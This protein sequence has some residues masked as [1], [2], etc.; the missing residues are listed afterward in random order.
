MFLKEF[1]G[2]NALKDYFRK[3]VSENRVPH[4]IL[5]VG[6]EGH[7]KLALSLGLAALLQCNNKEN[8]QACGTC[9]SCT[10]ASQLIHPDIHFSFPVIKKE[11][12]LKR[13]ETTSQHF[14]EQWRSFVAAHPYGNINDWMDHLGASDKS[15]NINVAECNQV[16]K[17]LG[18]KTYE[19]K[20]KI[21]IIWAAKYLGKEGNR[22][23]KLIEEPTPDTIII[24]I[25]DNRNALLNTIRSRCQIINVPPFDDVQIAELIEAESQLSA[26]DQQELTYLAAGNMRKVVQML[27][28]S[29]M[30][31]SEDILSWLRI[32][33]K[34]DPDEI[35]EFVDHLLSKGK[36]DLRNFMS[37]G[38][39]FL[40]EYHMGIMTGRLDKLR[41]TTV[42]KDVA[43]KMQKI[44]DGP[45]TEAL[46][47]LMSKGISLINRNVSL[48]ILIINLTLEIHDILRSTVDS[49][50]TR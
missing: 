31:Y 1:P 39:H 46:E 2:Q 5:M 17:N 20:Y 12:S 11:G 4:A 37:Y 13:A 23:L 32:G 19:G 44:I 18:L 48:K 38:L 43:V 47:K 9:S 8:D 49:L 26:S 3:I 27:D 45:K 22:L 33:Y 40:R 42:E 21:Q 28:Q 24:L 15:P 34:S 50:V 35:F 36:Q 14:M 6:G 41:L 7:G 16:I 25:D 29:E 10:K 30:N